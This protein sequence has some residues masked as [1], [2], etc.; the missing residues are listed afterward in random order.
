MITFSVVIPLYNKVDTIVRTLESVQSQTYKD[1]EVVIVDD[2]SMDGGGDAASTYRGSFPL[3]IV[4]QNN[5]GV[6]LARNKG[7]SE[8]VGRYIA[9]LDADDEWCPD[10]LLELSRIIAKFPAAK[11]IGTDY[12][13][14]VNHKIISGM[15]RDIIEEIDMFNEW[16]LRNPVNS[17]TVA[18]RRDFFIESGGFNG[19]FRYYEDAELLFRLALQTRFCVSR[20]VL[21]QYNTDAL[22]RATGIRHDQCANPHWKMAESLIK[23]GEAPYSL[24]KCVVADLGKIVLGHAMRLNSKQIKRIAT[25]YP[26]IF[27]NIFMSRALK[28]KF[29]LFILYPYIIG[30]SIIVRMR[31]RSKICIGK[32]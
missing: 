5:S 1:F 13:C 23:K 20:R 27:R 16:P 17:S 7:A 21:C 10:F 22:H 8:S 26:C 25:A 24:R 18:I 4:R 19:K 14:N 31:I 15:D 28:S 30:V 12:A 29:G 9:F 3:K 2:G 6:S 11:V 32:I